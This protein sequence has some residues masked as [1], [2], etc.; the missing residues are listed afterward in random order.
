MIYP[1]K[2]SDTLHISIIS[3]RAIELFSCS[4]NPTLSPFTLL[5]YATR[6]KLV[7]KTCI[8]SFVFVDT[9]GVFGYKNRIF[10][11]TLVALDKAAAR[12]FISDLTQDWTIQCH[13]DTETYYIGKT[14]F[15]ANIE[16]PRYFDTKL[17]ALS[18]G[19]SQEIS[20]FGW[21]YK[22]F[23]EQGQALSDDFFYNK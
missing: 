2:Y 19:R 18:K 16:Q 11:S 14:K 4:P 15:V 20:H 3:T 7:F 17:R 13:V 6:W 8:I 5:L 9:N 10:Y 22:M 1:I 23:K 12:Q 21:V